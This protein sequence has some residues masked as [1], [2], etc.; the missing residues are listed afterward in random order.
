MRRGAN[1]RCHGYL[2]EFESGRQLAYCARVPSHLPSPSGQLWGH[3]LDGDEHG[4]CAVRLPA[5]KSEPVKQRRWR[6]DLDPMI[7]SVHDYETFEVVRFQHGTE[8][9]PKCM[10]RHRDATGRFWFGLP[11]DVRGSGTPLYREAEAIAALRAG[12]P[13]YVVE[14]E[15][16]VDAITNAGAVATCNAFGAEKFQIRHARTIADAISNA[17]IRIVR[18]MD[19]PGLRHARQV[20]TRLLGAGVESA[21]I[22]MLRPA[23]G[24]DVRD[25]LS[26]GETLATLLRADGK[27]R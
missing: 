25:H 19:E 17:S 4:R 9:L 27:V 23:V 13:L 21:R 1:K 26:R 16:D 18:D 3:W 10:P 11:R 15:S 22:E 6:S 14:G 7:G 20:R 8:N 24:N 12:T 5:P 2:L